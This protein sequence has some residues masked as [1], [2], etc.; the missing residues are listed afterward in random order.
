MV[1]TLYDIGTGRYPEG[2]VAAIFADAFKGRA[3]G[4]RRDSFSKTSSIEAEKLARPRSEFVKIVSQN[5]LLGALLCLRVASVCMASEALSFRARRKRFAC[6]ESDFVRNLFRGA[7]CIGRVPPPSARLRI[8]LA[9]C[10]AAGSRRKSP[11]KYVRI[12]RRRSSVPIA[13]DDR[14]GRAEAE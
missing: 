2:S 10:S 14:V 8:V 12:E 9:P 11:A 4:A 1:G 13:A 6:V 5:L 7:V 3:H